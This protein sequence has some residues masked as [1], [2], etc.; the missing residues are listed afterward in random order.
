MTHYMYFKTGT[1]EFEHV[2]VLPALDVYFAQRGNRRNNELLL[3]AKQCR[4]VLPER[5]QN[6][7]DFTLLGPGSC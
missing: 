1:A 3:S 5:L 7:I 4:I 6:K 2:K